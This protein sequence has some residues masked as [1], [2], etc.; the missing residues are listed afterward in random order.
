VAAMVESVK[1]FASL[2]FVP[3][4]LGPSPSLFSSIVAT[5][6]A[7]DPPF[8]M[9]LEQKLG[10]LPYVMGYRAGYKAA[11]AADGIFICTHTTTHAR[12]LSLGYALRCTCTCSR[13]RVQFFRAWGQRIRC[14]I[15]NGNAGKTMHAKLYACINGY[16]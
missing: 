5:P 11:T 3:M 2:T 10:M 13:V 4:P 14:S 16:V 9:I 15:Q 7:P 1:T 12:M 6:L 8:G